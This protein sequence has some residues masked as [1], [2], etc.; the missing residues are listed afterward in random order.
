MIYA[1]NGAPAVEGE[2]VEAQWVR[3]LSLTETMRDTARASDWE[4][5]SHLESIRQPLL[6]SVMD[7]PVD[8]AEAGLIAS[9]IQTLLDMDAE[10]RRLGRIR[11]DELQAHLL[12]IKRTHKA[13]LVY[14]AL[15]V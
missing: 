5:V 2:A 9:N 4:R 12:Q 7:Q 13:S 6:R 14:S 8:S 1:D 10:I 15:G 3:V 11:L